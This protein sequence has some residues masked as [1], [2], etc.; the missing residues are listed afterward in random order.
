[1]TESRSKAI[2]LLMACI[3]ALHINRNRL[4]RM[5]D[6][7]NTTVYKAVNGMPIE[8]VSVKKIKAKLYEL[9]CGRREALECELNNINALIARVERDELNG[10]LPEAKDGL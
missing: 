5:S 1:M 8:A 2:C 9:L 6:M 4:A 3:E 7:N 10:L